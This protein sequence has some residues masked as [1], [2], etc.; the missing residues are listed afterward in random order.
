MDDRLLTCGGRKQGQGQHSP[1]PRVAVSTGALLAPLHS[2]G[3]RRGGRRRSSR[4]RRD[5]ESFWL[6]CSPFV[7]PVDSQDHDGTAKSLRS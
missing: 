5:R 7:P 4:K 3:R 1:A 2:N 6:P